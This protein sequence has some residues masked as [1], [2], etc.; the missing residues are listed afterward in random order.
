MYF[1]IFALFFSLKGIFDGKSISQWEHH[2]AVITYDE[3]IEYY[4]TRI[5]SLYFDD[6]FRRIA[7]WVLAFTLINN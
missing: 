5:E 3:G 2:V 1:L 4:S 7:Q 6:N